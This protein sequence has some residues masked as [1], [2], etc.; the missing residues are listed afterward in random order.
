MPG[1]LTMRHYLRRAADVLVLNL[2]LAT[3]ANAADIRPAQSIA[4]NPMPGVTIEGPI[5]PGDFA[6][7]ASLVL[8]A[9]A[10]V[11]WLASPGGKLSEALRMGALIRQLALEVRAPVDR[12]RPLVR[13][14]NPE[15]NTCASACFFLYAA[16]V[17]RQGSVLGI[18]KPS[19][20]ADEYFALGLDGSVAAHRRIQEAT[21]DYLDQMGVPS[22]YASMMMAASSSGMIWLAPEDIARDLT[23]VAAGY[24]AW[25]QGPCR[26]QVV[27]PGAADLDCASQLLAEIQEERRQRTR[28]H[29]RARN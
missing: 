21:A 25:F 29:F 13:L 15:N 1:A 10:A 7:L 9:R 17:R 6:K 27:Q 18:H 24:E 19:L 22:K 8:D 23:G 3:G 20:P 11:V 12:S 28:E 4:G 14:R 26:T 2:V 5:A 16:G